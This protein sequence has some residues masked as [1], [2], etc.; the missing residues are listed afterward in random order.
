MKKKKPECEVWR[1]NWF[2]IFVCVLWVA[3]IIFAV[4]AV[5]D[6]GYDEGARQ[7][8]CQA[9]GFDFVTQIGDFGL[10]CINE[11]TGQTLPVVFNAENEAIPLSGGAP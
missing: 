4:W 8:S 11:T 9:K 10:F 6:S 5:V 3:F 7:L 2:I 1:P